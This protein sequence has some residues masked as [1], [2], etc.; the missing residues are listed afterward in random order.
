MP[1]QYIANRPPAFLPYGYPYAL[2]AGAAGVIA[3][4]IRNQAHNRW[5]P[6]TVNYA[7]GQAAN[8][9][10]RQVRNAVTSSW[11]N[12]NKKKK[13]STQ[14]RV[15]KRYKGKKLSKK[16]V[17]KSIKFAKLGSVKTI[18]NG[19][20]YTAGGQETIYL[21]HGPAVAEVWDAALRAVVKELM[22]QSKRHIDNWDE[23][24]D[25]PPGIDS[26]TC[27]FTYIANPALA[28]T[29]VDSSFTI[30]SGDSYQGVVA[31]LKSQIATS[32][33]N[34][35]GAEF[36]FFRLYHTDTASGDSTPLAKILA[37]DFMLRYEFKSYIR[38][39]NQTLANTATDDLNS[40]NVANNPLIGKLYEGTKRQNGFRYKVGRPAAMANTFLC[41]KASGLI[42]AKSSTSATTQLQKPPPGW[43]FE[44]RKVKTIK[45]NPGDIFSNLIFTKQ[46]INFNRLCYMLQTYIND[47]T[48]QVMHFGKASMFALEKMLDS[49]RSTGEAMKIG[50]ELAQT[51]ACYGKY[52]ERVKSAPIVYV[53]TAAL[54]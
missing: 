3:N 50:Y 6:Q 48:H 37:K 22:K 10:G 19:G 38:C 7:A 40:D 21:G 13:Y 15:S 53:G 27:L 25:F 34:S 26:L 32:I 8:F 43:F 28:T 14:G 29:L 4:Q 2:A 18:E 45:E 9:V 49:G 31:K 12:I 1:R 39:Q 11:Q 16:A 35:Y 42:T 5:I 17:K 51:Y 30:V 33:G 20:T 24:V 54:T 52:T 47:G 44:T 23:G 41:D 46:S 36:V